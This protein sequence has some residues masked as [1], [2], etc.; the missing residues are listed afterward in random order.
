MTWKDRL[1]ETIRLE[2]PNGDI[3]E[4]EWADNDRSIERKLGLFDAPGTDGTEV[5]DLGSKGTLYPLTLYF[6]GP[7]NDRAAS[8]FVIASSQKGIWAILHPVKG[9][10]SLYLSTI[11]EKVAPVESGNIT[12]IETEWIEHTDKDTTKSLAELG[13]DVQSQITELN[14]SSFT[15]FIDNVK[16]T[17]SKAIG[18]L[19]TA[20]NKVTAIQTI[21][22]NALYSSD[23]TLLSQVDSILRNIDTTLAADV[24]DL[25]VLAGSIQNLVQLPVLATTDSSSRLSAYSNL[26][27]N[28]LNTSISGGAEEQKNIASVQELT[29]VS[30]LGALGQIA[31]TSLLTTRAQAIDLMGSIRA[32][33]ETV[34]DS[35]DAVQE[36]FS[37]DDIDLQYFS[38]SQ[39]YSDT[40]Q[41]I[42][43]GMFYLLSVSFDLLIEKVILISAPTSPWMLST[44]EYGDV[45]TDENFDLFIASNVLKNREILLLPAGRTVV[46]YV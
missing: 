6:E 9:Q 42:T 14:D 46:V 1:L 43:S 12:I 27:D 30:A 22:L 19:K 13:T 10:L 28:T 38:Q 31:V 40:V 32:Q 8:N 44:K 35:L 25:A 11:T 23:A 18:A 3:F 29:A 4:V 17:T 16:Q 26:I 2:S 21:A 45:N 37:S 34:T 36:S 7:D 20:V 24:I 33:F 41:V 15:Q 39:S 5:Q